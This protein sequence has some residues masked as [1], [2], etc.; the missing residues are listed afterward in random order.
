MHGGQGR[1]CSQK[2]KRSLFSFPAFPTNLNND[3]LPLSWTFY[4]FMKKVF[5]GRN[6]SGEIPDKR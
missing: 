5:K 6:C 4:N 1:E 3:V 2:T